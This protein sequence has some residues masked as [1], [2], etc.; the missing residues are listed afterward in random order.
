MTVYVL[1]SPHDGTSIFGVF[2]SIRKAAKYL[3][4]EADLGF[5]ALCID[6]GYGWSEQFQ[7]YLD[8]REVDGV[9]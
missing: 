7:V 8:K 5:E 9:I 1:Y 4:D 3:L 2:S 6:L